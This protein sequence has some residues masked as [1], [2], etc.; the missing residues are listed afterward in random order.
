MRTLKL[1][2]VA[3]LRIL[4]ERDPEGEVVC[5]EKRRR[6]QHETSAGGWAGGGGCV[7]G[8]AGE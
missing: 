3:T 5:S 8:L 2:R 6:D 1:S 7:K 4:E